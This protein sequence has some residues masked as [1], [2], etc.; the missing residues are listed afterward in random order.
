VEPRLDLAMQ[1]SAWTGGY[2]LLVLFVLASALVTLGARAASQAPE[3]PPIRTTPDTT[4]A[5]ARV[6]ARAWW[7]ILAALPSSLMLGVTTYLTT[8]VAP[9]PLLWVVP[10]ALYLSA[11]AIAFAIPARKL[12]GFFPPVLVGVTALLI[13]QV[14]IRPVWPLGLVAT[15]HLLAFFAGSLMCLFELAARRPRLAS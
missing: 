5:S 10:L 14:L 7:L 15:L 3:V 6:R 8:D 12:R 4:R 13:P 11:F 9:V 1:S 2:G